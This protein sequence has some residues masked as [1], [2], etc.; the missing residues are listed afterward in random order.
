M[1]RLARVLIDANVFVAAWTFDVLLTL[2][3]RVC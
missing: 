1:S 2:A 3:D